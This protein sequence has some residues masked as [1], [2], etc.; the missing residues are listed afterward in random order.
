[1]ATYH[2]PVDYEVEVTRAERQSTASKHR[3]AQQKS[4]S[5][6]PILCSVPTFVKN[7]KKLC[8]SKVGS[9][10]IEIHGLIK[11]K[12]VKYHLPVVKAK[13]PLRD[14]SVEEVEEFVHALLTLR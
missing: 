12:G 6:N 10:Y 8:S 5:R 2:L 13:I 9:K 11:E 1:M 14:E 7:G 3:K 4:G